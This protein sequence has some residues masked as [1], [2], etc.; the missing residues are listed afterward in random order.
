MH[1][2]SIVRGSVPLPPMLFEAQLQLGMFAR[3]L[4]KDPG[5]L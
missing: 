4:A 3:S 2:F 5:P 1:E